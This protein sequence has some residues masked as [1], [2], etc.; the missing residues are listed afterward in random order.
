MD[1][2]YKGDET[3]Q[4]AFDLGFYPSGATPKATAFP[5]GNIIKLCI[6][7][8]TKSNALSDV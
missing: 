7:S 1:R 5:L 6:G 8:A 4:L 2:A 3:R